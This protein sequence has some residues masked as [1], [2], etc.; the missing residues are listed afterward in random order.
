MNSHGRMDEGECILILCLSEQTPCSCG[1]LATGVCLASRLVHA[2]FT[3][4]GWHLEKWARSAA[5]YL[6]DRHS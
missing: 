1:C 6:K 3:S 4:L 2:S 5:C